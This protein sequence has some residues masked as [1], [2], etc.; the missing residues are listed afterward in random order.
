MRRLHVFT[1]DNGVS[2]HSAAKALGVAPLDVRLYVAASTKRDVLHHV[3][4]AG[5]HAARPE[6]WNKTT[7]NQVKAMCDAPGLLDS[8]GDMLAIGRNTA[9]SP[10]V[11][12]LPNDRSWTTIGR[13][14]PA[15]GTAFE[16]TLAS[17]SGCVRRTLT[18]EFAEDVP[19]S[20]VQRM[21]ECAHLGIAF[22]RTGYIN[23]RI[24]TRV[25]GP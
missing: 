25:E 1:V 8:D 3:Y 17:D 13:I 16:V 2:M 24:V 10:I 14:R 5:I 20:E 22:G 18:I 4:E 9:T 6:M 19:E 11:R 23:G 21:I 12:W 15:A 7:C